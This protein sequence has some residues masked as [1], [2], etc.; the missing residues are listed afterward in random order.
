MSGGKSDSSGKR[1]RTSKKLVIVSVIVAVL[2]LGSVTTWALLQPLAAVSSQAETLTATVQSG[3]LTIG[4]TASGTTVLGSVVQKIGSGLAGTGL[5]VAEVLAAAGESVVQGQALLKL[6]DE[7]IAAARTDL[8]ATAATAQIKLSQAEINHA[9][10]LIS[11]QA[12]RLSNLA[13]ASTAKQQYNATLATLSDAVTAA[14]TKLD[15]A[16][17]AIADNPAAIAAAAESI[18]T[19]QEEQTAAADTLALAQAVLTQ[20]QAVFNQAEKT[21]SDAKTAADLAAKIET[22]AFAYANSNSATLSA[23]GEYAAFLTA[24][25]ADRQTAANKVTAA[26][27][28]CQATKT[29]LNLAQ[30][31]VKAA[32]SAVNSIKQEITVLT[33]TCSSLEQTLRQAQTNLG[34]YQLK[35]DQALN[36]QRIQALEAEEL[37]A[38]NLLTAKNAEFLYT[39]AVQALDKTLASAQ[40]T[41]S[42]AEAQLALFE[43]AIA[44]GTIKALYD[45]KLSSIG[46]EADDILSTSTAVATYVNSSLLTVEVTIDQE[47]I[48]G[49]AV[50]DEV[51]VTFSTSAMRSYKGVITSIATTSGSTSVSDV[52]Y[53]V[54]VRVTSNLTGLSSGLTAT[55]S[56]VKEELTDVLYL[57]ETAVYSGSSGSYA[58]KLENGQTTDVPITTGSS[59]GTYIVITGGLKSGDICVIS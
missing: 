58:R 24:V 44:D 16:A 8:A 18:A 45:G 59:N 47:N 53:A 6:T 46:Y 12:E 38:A 41:A 1:S 48:A 14:K 25:T 3:N 29:A 17:A 40:K 5:E 15:A 42:D 19:H 33:Q 37:Y 27:P 9:S 36:S 35:Y 23:T 49:I 51:P 20:K 13:L 32:E 21:W 39:I 2:A 26:E 56:F 57:P 43:A 52:N 11:A 50:G 31:D 34:S 7:S 10:S 28:A 22:Y 4:V 55:V 54:T 30:A